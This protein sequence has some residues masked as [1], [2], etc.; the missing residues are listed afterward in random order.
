M[1]PEGLPRGIGFQA[2]GLNG[3]FSKEDRVGIHKGRME[4]NKSRPRK[5][6]S[7]K[8]KEKGKILPVLAK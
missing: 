1:V 5:E 2:G 8:P 7:G 4:L 6:V 3:I